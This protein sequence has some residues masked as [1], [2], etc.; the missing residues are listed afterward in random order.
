MNINCTIS[1]YAY[2]LDKHGWEMY[3]SLR[4]V[5]NS[6]KYINISEEK[7]PTAVKTGY[8][9]HFFQILEIDGYR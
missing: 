3:E 5:F 9:H 1:Y 8:K 7:V 4:T 6:I 2:I